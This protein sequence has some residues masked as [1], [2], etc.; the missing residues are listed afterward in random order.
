MIRHLVTGGCSFS[1]GDNDNGWVGSLTHLLHDHNPNLTTNHTGRNSSGQEL[2]QK[3]VMAAILAAIDQGIDKN[4]ILVA[5]M[6]SGTSR[7]SWFI[8]NPTIIERMVNDWPNFHG[9]MTHQFLNLT[10]DNING[11]G[12]FYTKNGSEFKY[13]KQGGWYLTVNG[14]DSQLEFVQQHYML[15]KEVNGVGKTHSSLEN[16]IMLQNFCKLHGIKLINQFFMKHVYEDII[17]HRDHEIINYLYK[18]LDH[19]NTIQQGMFEYLHKFINVAED[20]A[21][22]LSHDDR[23]SLQNKYNLEYFA[24]DGFHPSQ[25]GHDIWCKDILFPLVKKLL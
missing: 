19:T 16:I 8:D 23:K 20:H 3:R 10:D 5:V 6:W 22:L 14:S 11:D 21:I 2:I 18:Q 24:Q 7:K 12:V 17:K 13:N 25:Q 1:T 4:E 9:G 15:D